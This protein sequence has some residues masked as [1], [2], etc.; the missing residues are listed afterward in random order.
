[1]PECSGSPDAEKLFHNLLSKHNKLVRPVSNVSELVRVKMALKFSQ[2]VNMDEKRQ[3]M[4]SNVWL[5][6]RL[7]SLEQNADGNYQ[8]TLMTKATLYHNGTVAWEPPV[9][10]KSFCEIDIQ[11]FPFDIQKCSMKFGLWTYSGDLADLVHMSN[12]SSSYLERGIDLSDYSQS[13]EWDILEVPGE[14][15]EV[16]YPCCAEPFLDITYNVTLRR[17]TL[18]YTVNLIIP[19]VVISFLTVLVFYLPSDSGEKVTLCVS[20]L[21]A[22]TVFFLMLIEIIPQSSL[23]VPMFGK[24]LLFTMLLVT[25]S[26]CTTICVLNV[27]FRSPSTHTMGPWTKKIFLEILPA[28]LFIKRPKDY[29]RKTKMNESLSRFEEA[30]MP[31]FYEANKS[32]SVHGQARPRAR[33]PEDIQKAIEGIH[34]IA[35]HLRSDDEDMSIRQDWKYVAMVMDRFF[36]WIFSLTC[37][38]GTYALISSPPTL[39]N[40]MRA[41]GTTDNGGI[42]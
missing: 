13:V 21:L 4:T 16:F 35:E 38:I 32:N 5:K 8:V 22:L 12:M 6:Q 36:L 25:A 20:I 34:Y 14:R 27:H 19:C 40:T 18:F 30:S 31:S 41:I 42:S 24:Y 28:I 23:S 3:I 39:H 29:V 10:Y 26:I 11:Y 33:L 1:F 15:H 2:L 17:K 9:I 7:H 37:V